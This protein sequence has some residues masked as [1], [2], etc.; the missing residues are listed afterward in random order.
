MKTVLAGICLVGIV[1]G[2]LYLVTE[3]G[4]PAPQQSQPVTNSSDNDFKAL[5]VQ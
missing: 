4:N 5:K 3:S 2:A 1:L